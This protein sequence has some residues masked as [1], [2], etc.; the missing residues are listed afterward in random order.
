M[1]KQL[2]NVFANGTKSEVK[3]EK[4]TERRIKQNEERKKWDVCS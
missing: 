1:A 3:E 2:H 4:K